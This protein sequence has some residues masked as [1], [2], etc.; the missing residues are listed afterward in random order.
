VIYNFLSLHHHHHIFKYDQIDYYYYNIW[1][2]EG[3]NNLG[4]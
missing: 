1:N 4:P 2:K 3:D